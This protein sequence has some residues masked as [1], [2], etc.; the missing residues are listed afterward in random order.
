[1]TNTRNERSPQDCHP[2]GSRNP[3]LTTELGAPMISQTH[4]DRRQ[5][6]ELL[7]DAGSLTE[8]ARRWLVGAERALPAD[9]PLFAAVDIVNGIAHLK[10]AAEKIQRAEVALN[11]DNRHPVD[12]TGPLTIGTIPDADLDRLIDATIAPSNLG[13]DDR[14]CLGYPD[15]EPCNKPVR[16]Y[17]LAACAPELWLPSAG[18]SLGAYCSIEHAE[19]E[20]R[21]SLDEA[22]RTQ[23]TVLDGAGRSDPVNEIW[24]RLIDNYPHPIP[25]VP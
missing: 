3:S 6:I 19:A 15:A 10:K 13:M 8:L 18:A 24:R 4:E 12:P 5:T 9:A 1:M 22:K 11:L 20:L 17:A 14:C 21:P 2:E 7:A 25:A 23:S 16:Y